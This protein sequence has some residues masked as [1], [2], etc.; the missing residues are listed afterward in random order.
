MQQVQGLFNN[1]GQTGGVDGDGNAMAGPG[2]GQGMSNALGAARFGTSALSAVSNYN[3]QNAQA[4]NLDLEAGDEDIQA[5]QEYVQAQ[6]KSNLINRQYTSVIGRQLSDAAAG[7][8]DIASGSV[9]E[10]GRQA[11]QEADRQQLAVRTT[12]QMNAAER[13]S[14]AVMLRASANTDRSSAGF[15]LAS[16]LLTSALQVASL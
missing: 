4:D 8:V 5:R 12:A 2:G 10:E 14:R 9:Q 3:L 16:G 15:G 1:V 11:E 13:M 7:G 6:Q